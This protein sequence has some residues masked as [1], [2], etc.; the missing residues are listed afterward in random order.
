VPRNRWFQAV[1][2]HH[3]QLSALTSDSL[4]SFVSTPGEADIRKWHT[5]CLLSWIFQVAIASQHNIYFLLSYKF[6][7]VGD[8]IKEETPFDILQDPARIFTGDESIFQF[9]RK[10]GKCF[11]CKRGQKCAQS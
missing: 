5:R 4:T 8:A 7:Q 9:C 2:R 1:L 11:A 6:Q 3:R 10:T